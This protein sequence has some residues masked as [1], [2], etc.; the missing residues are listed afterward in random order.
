MVENAQV[1]RLVVHVKTVVGVSIAQK[2]VVVVESVNNKKKIE[3]KKFMRWFFIVVVGLA[4][5]GAIVGKKETDTKEKSSST[6]NADFKTVKITSQVNDEPV[7]ER[8]LEGNFI[9]SKPDE[10]GLVE[11]TDSEN[12][13]KVSYFI[14]SDPKILRFLNVKFDKNNPVEWRTNKKHDLFIIEK[15]ESL[16]F[17]F[18]D[19]HSVAGKVKG[20]IVFTK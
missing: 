17:I 16:G 2:T 3:M 5:I 4:I 11:I 18:G 9:K 6:V 7:V 14:E 8:I 15:T 10:L 20:T 12:R 1:L 19:R 13:L